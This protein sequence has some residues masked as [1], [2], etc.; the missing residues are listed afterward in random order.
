MNLIDLDYY[1]YG[2]H[3][4]RRINVRRWP[5]SW[6]TAFTVCVFAGTV[7]I[8]AIGFVGS[9]FLRDT[10]APKAARRPKRGPYR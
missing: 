2:V 4:A 9:L 1:R 5:W 10:E 3:K 8:A 6:R 7:P